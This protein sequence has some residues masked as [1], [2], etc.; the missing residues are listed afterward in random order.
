MRVAP[1]VIYDKIS[2]IMV[3]KPETGAPNAAASQT[4]AKTITITAPVLWRV[5]LSLEDNTA[6]APNKNVVKRR[7]A[8]A[9]RSP[10]FP[11]DI[12]PV[13]EVRSPEAAAQIAKREVLPFFS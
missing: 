1:I 11:S 3:N 2:R 8:D 4:R 6:K 10:S 5:V 12:L 9:I 13:V 7:I